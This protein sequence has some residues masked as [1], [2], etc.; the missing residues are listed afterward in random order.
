[1]IDASL[2]GAVFDNAGGNNTQVNN[3]FL[4]GSA[5][6]PILMDFGAPGQGAPRSIAGNVVQ[7]NIFA[8]WGGGTRQML[9]S[10]TGWS[11]EFLKPNGSDLNLYWSPDDAAAGARFPGGLTLPQWQGEAPDDKGVVLC[12]SLPGA[13]S[14]LVVSS[15][16]SFGWI[17][18]ATDRKWRST[19]NHS[20]VLN[21]DCEGAWPNCATGSTERTH[22]CA[23]VLRAPWT[24]HPAPPAVDNQAW[25]LNQTS[26]EMVADASGKCM[27]VCTRGGTVGGCDGKDGSIAQLAPCTGTAKQRWAHDARTGVIRST[28]SPSL[29]LTP[30]ARP[31]PDAFDRRSIIADPLFV[32]APNGNFDLQPDSP[33]IK[34]LGW[35]PI[36]PI[37]APTS[38]CGTNEE[39]APECL[40]LIF[41]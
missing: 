31:P 21:V 35:V 23:D 29:C 32:D 6:S 41:Q 13:E 11:S 3:I 39:S 27:E 17:H 19:G 30:P 18:N 20:L 22:I 38:R 24:P 14:S 16:C 8:W 28:T 12:G 26:G 15:N 9:A 36:P 1:M 10:Q 7:R 25:S 33:V 2:H 40:S 5:V 34:Q 4:G 37:T